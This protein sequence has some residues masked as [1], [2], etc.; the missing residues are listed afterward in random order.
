MKYF[1]LISLGIA[2]TVPWI[3]GQGQLTV[4]S[5]GNHWQRFLGW[6]PK[7]PPPLS[8]PEGYA[9]AISQVG[10][11][12]NRFFCVAASSLEMTNYYFRGWAFCFSDANGRRALVEVSFDKELRIDP[13]SEK[14][15]RPDE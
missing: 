1:L 14:L 12:T 9:L 4:G 11:A 3:L 6:D 15:L 13:R 8:L 10:T 5:G 2:L 7:Q